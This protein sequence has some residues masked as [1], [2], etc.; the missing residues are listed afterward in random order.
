MHIGWNEN[1]EG[2][3]GCLN[4]HSVETDVKMTSGRVV[5][6]DSPSNGILVRLAFKMHQTGLQS[7]STK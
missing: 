3:E 5:P 6:M 2:I 1:N 7:A 4:A